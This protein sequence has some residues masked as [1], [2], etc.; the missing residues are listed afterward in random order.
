MKEFHG[1]TNKGPAQINVA[2][3]IGCLRFDWRGNEK[4]ASLPTGEYREKILHHKKHWK[5]LLP[6]QSRPPTLDDQALEHLY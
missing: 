2:G 6:P 4:P 5:A 3:A 1:K